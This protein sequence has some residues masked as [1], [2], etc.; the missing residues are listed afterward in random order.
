MLKFIGNIIRYIFFIYAVFLVIVFSLY[1]ANKKYYGGT[2]TKVA[3]Y[4]FAI[5]DNDY[6]SPDINSGDFVLIRLANPNIVYNEGDYV[7]IEY[8]DSARL[9][10]II[11][12]KEKETYIVNFVN[13]PD[14][15]PTAPAPKEEN[16]T[17]NKKS[18][19]AEEEEIE[20]KYIFT[21]KDFRDKT[22]KLND[23]EGKAILYGPRVNE[24]YKVLTSWWLIGFIVLYLFLFPTLFY[25]RYKN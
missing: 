17:K 18:A 13:I 24:W 8:N 3:G 15:L 23:I 4:S 14:P 22:Y 5:P 20:Q 25:K 12:E 6:L 7:F 10:K 11:K 21:E 9:E 1:H 2:Y 16:T 19:A